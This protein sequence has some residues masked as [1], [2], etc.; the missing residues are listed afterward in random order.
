MSR[1]VLLTVSMALAVLLT[2]GAV[3]ALAPGA[4]LDAH[5][6][7]TS[8]FIGSTGSGPPGRTVQ[9]FKAQNTGLLTDA[10]ARL[11]RTEGLGTTGEIIAQIVTI[12][13]ANNPSQVLAETTIPASSVGEGAPNSTLATFSFENPAHVTAGQS[14]GLA[15]HMTFLGLWWHMADYTSAPNSDAYPDGKW[16]VAW[17]DNISNWVDVTDGKKD[18]IFS[19]YVVPS[20]TG[21]TDKADCKNGGY[22][23]FGFENQGQCIKAVKDAT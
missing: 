6:S 3:Q 18:G 10:Q 7:D 19:I 5:T 11:H 1:T 20:P 16:M 12:P 15:L 9:T 23:D 21:P 8:E 22:K 4:V 17:G 2:T 13:T 14:Y